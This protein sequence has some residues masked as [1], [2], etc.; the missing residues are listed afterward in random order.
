[1]NEILTMTHNEQERL[2]VFS[3]VDENLLT[4]TEAATLLDVSER[5]FYRLIKRYHEH[6]NTAVVHGLRG[7]PSNHGFPEDKRAHVLKVYR[8]Q[9]G[10]YGPTLYAEVLVDEHNIRVDH[11]TIRRWLLHDGIENFTR[12]KRPHRKKRERRSAIGELI[13]F[14]GS[15][16][17]WFEGRGP[18][19]CLLH[20]IDDASGRAFLRFVPSENSAD[21]LRTLRAY[22]ERYGIP[23]ALYTDRG[24]VFYAEKK[25]TDVGRAMELLGVQM[26]FANSPQA[27]GRVERG[28]R[29]HQ[30]RL[31]K[32]LRQAGISTIADANHFLEESY[33]DDHNARFACT[34]GLADIHHS[35]E[36]VNLTNIFCFQTQRQV[37]NDY[38][39]TLEGQYIQL[40]KSEVP[41]PLP[42]QY[43]T[44]RRWLDGSLHIVWKTDELLF[45]QLA[46][47][48][49]RLP[50]PP[51]KPPPDHPWRLKPIGRAK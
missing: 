29:T 13:Q 19:C 6:G 45:T 24:S 30:D 17:D 21:T 11:E 1:M 5:Q 38:T 14:D 26:I 16:H 43:V 27:K 32:A 23:K 51:R 48:P 41:L 37:H 40:E 47:K 46:R 35:A 34:E 15:P 33:L 36:G 44:V 28:N 31:V 49:R 7:K 4:Y 9:F 42:K 10:D 22:I 8:A 25:L 39:I 20:A 50:V 18:V 2:K 3:Q 12:K